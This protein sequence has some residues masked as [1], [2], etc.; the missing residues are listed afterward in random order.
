MKPEIFQRRSYTLQNKSF[1][2]FALFACSCLTRAALAAH[3]DTQ[4]AHELF[5]L[6]QTDAIKASLAASAGQP[7]ENLWKAQLILAQWDDLTKAKADTSEASSDYVAAIKAYLDSQKTGFDG[8]WALD[9]AQFVLSKLAQ[10]IVTRLEYWG[11]NRRDRAAL[12]PLTTLATR[13][14]ALGAE[15]LNASLKQLENTQPFDE[16]IYQK[17]YATAADT[18]YYSAWALYF[19]AMALDSGNPARTLVLKDAAALLNDWAVDAPDNGVNFQAYLLRGKV[20]EEIGDFARALDDL[21]KAQD[22]KAPNW[23]QYQAR[24][25]A[26]VA[27]LRMHDF[28]AADIRLTEFKRWIPHDNADARLSAD[29]LEFRL[30]WARAGEV[31]AGESDTQRRMARRQAISILSQVLDADPR[32]RELV[33]QQLAA[34][35]PDNADL[36]TLVPLQQVALAFCSSQGQRG[37]TPDS[38]TQLKRAVDAAEAAL[39]SPTIRPAEKVEATYLAGACNAV[40]GNLPEA[41]RYEVAFAELAPN[42]PRSRPLVELAL[43]QI[44]ELRK[45]AGSANQTEGVLPPELRPLAERALH[46]SADIFGDT[47]WKYAQARMLEDA[48]QSAQAAAIYD[49]VPQD[50]RN[51]LDA[52]YRLVRLAAARFSQATGKEQSTVAAAA[53]ELFKTA[54]RFL[55]VLDHPPAAAPKDVLD[56]ARAYCYDIW[57]L[58]AAAALDPSVKQINLAIELLDKL[59][60]NRVQLT[61][62]QKGLVLRYRIQAYQLAGQADKAFTVVQEYAQSTGQDAIAVIRAMALS[63]MEEINKVEPTNPQEARRLASYLA[64]LLDPIIQ[65]SEKDGKADT[66]YE[67]KLIQIDMLTRAGQFKDAQTLAISLQSKKDIR[68]NL[69]EARSIFAEAQSTRDKDEFAKAQDY[70]SRI[71]VQLTPGS[72]TFWECWLKTVQSMEARQ[73]SNAAEEIKRALSDLKAIYGTKFGGDLLKPDFTRLATKYG[74]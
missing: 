4:F 8:A 64:K 36:T 57:I 17:A 39:Q 62:S 14:L 6:R 38:R 73:T 23:V 65:Q 32:F 50:D 67:Y 47:R 46:L 20:F 60:Q 5:H 13:L 33:Y 58:E 40:L 43:Q 59:E 53:D 56:H 27:G 41:A 72:E 3:P 16:K 42:D 68:A 55:D 21:A 7:A 63:T 37:D 28:A 18:R 12:E 44:G 54:A 30:A 25:Q 9:H 15:N 52:R 29:M 61:E 10:P 26:V 74:I 34:E 70:F 71:L 48:D 49:A 69:A 1:V 31:G 66:A 19:R 35:I 22:E 2:I 11:N 45:I 24:Y 51:Y